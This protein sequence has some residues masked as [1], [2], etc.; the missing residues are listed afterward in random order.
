MLLEW[1]PHLGYQ[2]SASWI[3]IIIPTHFYSYSCEYVALS[4][5]SSPVHPQ[6]PIQ[7]LHNFQSVVEA[8][9]FYENF[10]PNFCISKGLISPD[11]L[12]QI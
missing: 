6:S 8:A 10:F 12:N 4:H 2:G 3:E 5:E 9:F 11:T 7:I 1:D